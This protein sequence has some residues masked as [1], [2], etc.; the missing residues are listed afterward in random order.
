LAVLKIP[1]TKKKGGG[2]RVTVIANVRPS[3]QTPV[4]PKERKTKKG[5]RKKRMVEIL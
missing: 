4:S 2:C 1:N 3:V 5:G